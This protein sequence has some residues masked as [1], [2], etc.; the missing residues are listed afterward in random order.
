VEGE[1][2]ISWIKVTIA[3]VLAVIII[4]LLIYLFSRAES[5][6]SGELLMLQEWAMWQLNAPTVNVPL[7]A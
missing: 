3:V 5:A 4:G 1:K 6:Q 2:P 7:L